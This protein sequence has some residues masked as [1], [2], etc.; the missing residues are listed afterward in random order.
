M[1]NYFLIFFLFCSSF[2]FGQADK[3]SWKG[4]VVLTFDD[5]CISHY[6]FVAP[7][8]KKY[9]FG[10]T[11]YVCEFP[12]M[13]GDPTKSLSWSQIK[14]LAEMGFEIGNH[15]WHHKNVDAITAEEL[16]TELSYVEHKCDSLGIPKLTSFA[17]PAYHESPAAIQVLQRHGYLTARTGGD[18]PWEPG[19]E[20]PM[21][22]PSYTLKGDK[23]EDKQYF[24]DA[25][26]NA[27]PGKVIVFT[28]HGVP[29]I[30]HPWVNTPPEF[31]KEYLQYLYDNHYQVVSMSAVKHLTQS[32]QT[33]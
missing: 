11:F 7:L 32:K 18:K 33:E 30:A 6:T 14:E 20:D 27:A 25:L 3:P 9:G 12:G 2:V 31:F 23:P 17:Y 28:I 16:D 1:K 5:A 22:V 10:A 15:T 8:L 24:Y 13:F 29:D 26:K 4:T 19:A 21:H